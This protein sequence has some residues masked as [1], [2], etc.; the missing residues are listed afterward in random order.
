MP[1]GEEVEKIPCILEDLAGKEHPITKVPYHRVQVAL[2]DGRK[3]EG[4]FP[5]FASKFDYVL[6]PSL[7]TASDY[8]QFREANQALA[9]EIGNNAEL[10]RQFTE[11]ERELIE[12]GDWPSKDYTWHHNEKPGVL[13]LVKRKIHKATPHTGGRSKFLWGGGSEQ[14]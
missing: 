8:M 4:V 14:R 3:V 6:D 13:Q 10:R 9:R 12:E 5:K 7:Y 1:H 11:F 2:P